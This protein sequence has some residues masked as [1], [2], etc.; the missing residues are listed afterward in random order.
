MI[1]APCSRAIATEAAV[2][3]EA[4]GPVNASTRGSGLAWLAMTMQQR[5]RRRGN[6][7][8]PEPH[9]VRERKGGAVQPQADPAADGEGRDR[10]QETVQRG[11]GAR[12]L[13]K[14][15]D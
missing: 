12:G 7:H 5:P 9:A 1:S 10:H 6:A 3:P 13:R 14:G 15:T 8:A 4:V 2:L 11:R